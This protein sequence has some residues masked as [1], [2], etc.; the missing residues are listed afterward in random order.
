MRNRSVIDSIDDYK[1]VVFLYIYRGGGWTRYKQTPRANSENLANKH[2][3][4]LGTL[5]CSARADRPASGPDHPHLN[6]V[7]NICPLSFGGAEQTESN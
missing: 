4:K 6:L 1:S 7:S 2:N 5:I 3:K